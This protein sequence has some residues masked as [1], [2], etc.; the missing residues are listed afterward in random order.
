MFQVNNEQCYNQL[1]STPDL[2]HLQPET[3]LKSRPA[4]QATDEDHGTRATAT[5]SKQT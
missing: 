2:P 4:I 5:A 1:L 3:T